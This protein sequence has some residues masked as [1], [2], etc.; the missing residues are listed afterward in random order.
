MKKIVLFLSAF[1]LWTTAHADNH[2]AATTTNTPTVPSAIQATNSDANTRFVKKD[3]TFDDVAAECIF[4]QTRD[5]NNQLTGETVLIS[6]ASQQVYREGNNVPLV[7]GFSYEVVQG[8][9]APFPSFYFV[10]PLGVYLAPIGVGVDAQGGFQ[11]PYRQ[12]T[13]QGC[14]AA[15]MFDEQLFDIFKKGSM[16]DIQMF[17]DPSQ[18]PKVFKYS[19]KGFTA[20]TDFLKNSAPHLGKVTSFEDIEKLAK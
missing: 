7:A 11:V 1:S 18:E 10:S 19:L 4:E 2:G 6:C 15:F 8:N 13:R 5:A 3:Y 14:N 16:V 9:V 12:C 20:A 17:L